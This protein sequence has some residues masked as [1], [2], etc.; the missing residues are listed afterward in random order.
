MNLSS[1]DPRHQN[2]HPHTLKCNYYFLLWCVGVIWHA[3]LVMPGY[4]RSYTMCPMQRTNM[5]ESPSFT[6]CTDGNSFAGPRARLLH[7]QPCST[8]WVLI[9]LHLDPHAHHYPL[10]SISTLS[11]AT[12]QSQQRHLPSHLHS[13]PHSSFYTAPLHPWG[14]L[15]FH[16]LI[17][18]LSP[19]GMCYVYVQALLPQGKGFFQSTV[20]LRVGCP[21]LDSEQLCEQ[22]LNCTRGSQP[23]DSAL[24]QATST[25]S[26]K[27]YV[28]LAKEEEDVQSN[29]PKNWWPILLWMRFK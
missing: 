25:G 9:F 1:K 18:T 15:A 12:V 29:Q 17:Y 14:H 6:F 20:S 27:T 24:I 23:R 26:R 8:T 7:S 16:A 5:E 28:P 4:T 2:T 3:E 22:T 13:S 10:R 11:P 19:L 21:R